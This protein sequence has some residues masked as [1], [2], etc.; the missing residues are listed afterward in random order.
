M[1]KIK[2]GPHLCEAFILLAPRATLSA[3]LFWV[4]FQVF[5]DPEADK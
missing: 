4:Y 3:K 5:N 2:K 1:L